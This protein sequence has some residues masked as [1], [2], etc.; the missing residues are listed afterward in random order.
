LSTAWK[1]KRKE[2]MFTLTNPE[3][4]RTETDAKSLAFLQNVE[5]DSKNHFF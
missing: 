1:K 5:I 4:K 2:Q 3:E